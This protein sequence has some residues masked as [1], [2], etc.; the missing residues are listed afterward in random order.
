MP[1][2]T[3]PTAPDHE[4]FLARLKVCEQRVGNESKWARV[5]GISQSTIRGYTARKV[6]PPRNVLI[7]LARAAGVS[8][9][10][11]ATGEG[12]IEPKQTAAFLQ[13]GI[14]APGEGLE[15][16]AAAVAKA[17]TVP[18]EFARARL[19]GSKEI[20]ALRT[21]LG[22]WSRFHTIPVLGATL[23]SDEWPTWGVLSREELKNTAPA[24]APENIAAHRINTKNVG[25][26]FLAGDWALV[27]LMAKIA[28]GTY[29]VIGAGSSLIEVQDITIEPSGAIQLS[30]S[31][32]LD[33]KWSGQLFPNL[34]ALQKKFRVVGRLVAAIRVA[35]RETTPKAYVP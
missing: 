27:D 26:R 2:I 13:T 10:W 24:S 21:A 25:P 23:T 3:R 19:S 29:C 30:G 18:I 6:E 7:E 15:E 31:R 16:V 33:G 5:A 8:A 11:L 1:K 22:E 12:P 17:Y 35:A 34:E 32:D 9:L 4:A 28:T 14:S 20:K